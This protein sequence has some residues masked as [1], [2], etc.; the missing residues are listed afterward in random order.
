MRREEVAGTLEKGAGMERGWGDSVGREGRAVNVCLEGYREMWKGGAVRMCVCSFCPVWDSQLVCFVPHTLQYVQVLKVLLRS[1]QELETPDY[2]SVCQVHAC[3][4]H[5][6]TSFPPSP[7]SFP[8]SL[9]LSLSPFLPPPSFPSSFLPFLSLYLL[10]SLPSLPAS[11][12]PSLPH[13]LSSFPQCY[14]FLDNP[15]GTAQVLEKLAR[16][17]KVQIECWESILW[18][19]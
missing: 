17:T 18:S 6:H 14:I 3:Q 8:P 19:E 9:P 5:K 11:L 13:Y 4:I 1:Y 12:L 10:P 7:P 15:V 16:G 2:I